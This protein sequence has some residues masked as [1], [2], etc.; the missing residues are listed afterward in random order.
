MADTS[1]HFRVVPLHRLIRF[2]VIELEYPTDEVD[3]E[4]RMFCDI[5]SQHLNVYRPMRTINTQCINVKE[6]KVSFGIPRNIRRLH[7]YFHRCFEMSSS[8]RS[9]V[10]RR[11]KKC[12]QN[13]QQHLSP[14]R[15]RLPLNY[16][17]SRPWTIH[18][19]Q[20]LHCLQRFPF[21]THINGRY[22]SPIRFSPLQNRRFH[23]LPCPTP[24]RHQP[25]QLQS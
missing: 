17:K 24:K 25:Q 4:L 22:R 10:V 18:R 11:L 14:H 6:L 7:H 12:Q 1:I 16:G 23:P 20:R 5:R 9:F 19:Q 3:I 21:F 8:H 2:T 13:L 15:F